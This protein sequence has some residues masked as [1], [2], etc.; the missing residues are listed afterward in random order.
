MYVIFLC[1][2]DLY[3]T[4]SIIKDQERY[5][6]LDKIPL[7]WT[8]SPPT[9]GVQER[10][11]SH[12][13]RTP[14]SAQLPISASSN[15][16]LISLCID[17]CLDVTT[18]RPTCRKPFTSQALI[19]LFHSLFLSF[20]SPVSP[21]VQHLAQQ[22]LLCPQ[23]LLGTFLSP[24]NSDR[25]LSPE[26]TALLSGGN[27]IFHDLLPLGLFLIAAFRLV[28]ILPSQTPLTPAL[29]LMLPVMQR[30]QRVYSV[31]CTEKAYLW[32]LI[33]IEVASLLQRRI[34]CYRSLGQEG[35]CPFSQSVLY[36]GGVQDKGS[37]FSFRQA[38]WELGSEPTQTARITN[39]RQ[40]Q[41]RKRATGICS[42]H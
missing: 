38:D 29:N 5:I 11:D 16:D 42:E 24:A 31:L 30:S 19:P 1:C 4:S 41:C 9:T 7:P 27:F 12:P 13:S 23:P 37:G 28:F 22:N 35:N 8:S 20:P 34:L 3:I 15:T 10:P 17:H 6:Y 36:D 18:R 39:H 14:L 26:H 25:N 2:M 40:M 32:W 21:R 33:N